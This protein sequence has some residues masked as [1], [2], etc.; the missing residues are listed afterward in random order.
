[1]LHLA[2]MHLWYW[3]EAFQYAI[4]IRNL[5]PMPTLVNDVPYGAWTGQKPNVSHLCVFGSIGYAN[6]LKK[7]CGGKLAVMAIKCCLLGWWADKSKGYR[8]DN[9][10]TK[11]I[12][13]SRDVHFIKDETPT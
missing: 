11:T 5:L 7:V 9:L 2:H 6:I 13:S 8:L 3:G 1:M 10:E 12:I 4:H